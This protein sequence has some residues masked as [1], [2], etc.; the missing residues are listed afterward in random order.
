MYSSYSKAEKSHLINRHLAGE[1][2]ISILAATNIPR[3]TFYAWLKQHRNEAQIAK[4]REFTLKN[5]RILSDKVE[6]LEGIIKI[7]HTVNCAATAPL[8]EKLAALESL[9][10]QYPV[11]MLCEALDVSRGTF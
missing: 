8:S 7:L 2:I 11:R 3:S 5:F 9:H 10:C 4:S 1:P 6:R